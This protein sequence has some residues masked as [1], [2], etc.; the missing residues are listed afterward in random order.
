M[1]LLTERGDGEGDERR[2][3]QSTRHAPVERGAAHPQAA[4][5]Q[6]SATRIGQNQTTD[7]SGGMPQAPVIAAGAPPTRSGIRQRPT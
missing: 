4:N 1:Q 2:R 5:T 7:G 6:A 3:G